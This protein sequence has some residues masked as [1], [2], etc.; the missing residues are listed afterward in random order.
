[1]TTFNHVAP[2]DELWV[3]NG[4]QNSAFEA[5]VIDVESITITVEVPEK[6]NAIYTFDRTTGQAQSGPAI[7]RSFL[8]TDDDPRVKIILDHKEHNLFHEELVELASK[9]KW[10]P[11]EQNA[12]VILAHVEK[13]V[14]FVANADPLAL[15]SNSVVEYEEAK[16]AAAV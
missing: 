7:S 16:N 12:Q 11:N 2:G 15:V 3:I 14:A 13:W 9:F 4:H 6:D 8:A 1:M 5:N 10:D